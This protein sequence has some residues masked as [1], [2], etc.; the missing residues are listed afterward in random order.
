MR[1]LVV[2]ANDRGTIRPASFEGG[3]FM[4]ATELLAAFVAERGLAA[5]G[6]WVFG[7]DYVADL[8]PD[9]RWCPSEAAPA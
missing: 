6:C 9:I 1:I 8:H 3:T 4:A 7:D 2:V 5:E